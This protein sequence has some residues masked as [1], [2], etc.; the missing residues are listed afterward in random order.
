MGQ[1]RRTGRHA[2]FR[3]NATGVTSDPVSSAILSKSKPSSSII[4]TDIHNNTFE[5][6]QR[7]IALAQQTGRPL[8]LE[9]F[10]PSVQPYLDA[11]GKHEINQDQFMA[12][13]AKVSSDNSNGVVSE[14]VGQG[15]SASLMKNILTAV[16][17]GLNVQA[18]GNLRGLEKIDLSADDA[19][20]LNTYRTQLNN[21]QIAT[22]KYITTN[23]KEFYT[24]PK[25]LFAKLSEQMSAR[26]DQYS[27]VIQAE[28]KEQIDA[29]KQNSNPSSGDFQNAIATMVMASQPDYESVLSAS[30]RYDE[31][32]SRP[33]TQLSGE[34]LL[35][36]RQSLD[37]D[38]AADISQKIN[39]FGPMV[40]VYGAGHT[41]HENDLDGELRGLGRD[42]IVVDLINTNTRHPEIRAIN[43]EMIDSTDPNRFAIDVN[44]GGIINKNPAESSPT[45][46]TQPRQQTPDTSPWLPRVGNS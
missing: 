39:Q 30:Q 16:E 27:P 34:E 15:A 23:A 26:L 31:I 40:I 41:L 32:A 43:Q 33:H 19:A 13:I 29:I 5:N 42:V 3:D 46:P 18:V 38:I 11:L 21:C 4:I 7:A 17:N 37:P 9:M 1:G 25:E 12:M 36:L 2:D 8:A 22:T 14:F 20:F 6:H 35:K 44:T 45:G 24:N 28:I 10:P